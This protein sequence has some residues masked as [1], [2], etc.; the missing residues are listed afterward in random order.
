MNREWETR[1]GTA[2]RRAVS[3]AAAAFLWL[4]PPLTVLLAARMQGSCIPEGEWVKTAVAGM[5]P[6]GVWCVFLG[7]GSLLCSMLARVAG[8]RW[9]HAIDPAWL[10]AVPP[11]L[12]AGC[13]L[14]VCGGLAMETCSGNSPGGRPWGPALLPVTLLVAGCATAA[15]TALLKRAQRGGGDRRPR[16]VS[17]VGL[18]VLVP[19]MAVASWAGNSV[20]FTS[21]APLIDMAAAAAA[22]LAWSLFAPEARGQ[23]TRRPLLLLLMAVLAFQ[24][25]FSFSRLLIVSYGQIPEETAYDALRSGGEWGAVALASATLGVLL[26]VGAA[27]SATLFRRALWSGAL[28]AFVLTATA[29]HVCLSLLPAETPGA[30]AACAAVGLFLLPAVGAARLTGRRAGHGA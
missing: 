2:R 25:Y 13:A 4:A 11:F 12:A 19:L 29:A 17:A 3:A 14:A 20:H 6:A 15:L 23:A 27:L 1:E 26:P 24:L 16:F 28:A 10:R 9:S 5:L 8:A 7:M 18:I 22:A 21:M 30:W